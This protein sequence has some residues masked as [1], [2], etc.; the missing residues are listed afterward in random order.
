MNYVFRKN[1]NYF[2]ANSYS[3]FYHKFLGDNYLW[4]INQNIC[5]YVHK[6]Y[7]SADIV[8]SESNKV[9]NTHFLIISLER[10]HMYIL[11]KNANS[12]KCPFL[13]LSFFSM[14]LSWPFLSPI[15]LTYFLRHVRQNLRRSES[16]KNVHEKDTLDLLN[17][18]TVWYGVKAAAIEIF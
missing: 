7:Y 10:F 17:P 1:E 8:K 6:R 11:K 13:R 4:Q 18:A 2:L 16:E 5:I 3:N 9:S 14:V 15:I 12:C